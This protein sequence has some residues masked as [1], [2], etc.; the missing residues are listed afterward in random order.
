MST[1]V[2]EWQSVSYLFRS[3]VFTGQQI[4]FVNT[5][6][7]DWALR[8]GIMSCWAAHLNG[9]SFVR[10]RNWCNFEIFT[11]FTSNSRTNPAGA[12]E[13]KLVS[14][15]IWISIDD[16][17]ANEKIASTWYLCTASFQFVSVESVTI[18]FWRGNTWTDW[19]R[20]WKSIMSPPFIFPH[21]RSNFMK[22]C[23][24]FNE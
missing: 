20:I 9:N 11:S 18:C 19:V 24:G 8:R 21:T 7:R 4:N 16:F 17:K 14:I 5:H 1:S 13:M 12:S 22:Y 10:S 2:A 3:S 6:V 15:L 23:D